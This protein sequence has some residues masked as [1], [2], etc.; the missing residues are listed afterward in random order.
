MEGLQDDRCFSVNSVA[1]NV[2]DSRRNSRPQLP[3]EFS[4]TYE[5][6]DTS[7]GQNSRNLQTA[8]LDP[9]PSYRLENLMSLTG[10]G[11]DITEQQWGSTAGYPSI[12]SSQATETGVNYSE[13]TQRTAHTTDTEITVPHGSTTHEST[14]WLIHP[15]Q[16]NYAK[17]KRPLNVL[18]DM[19]QPKRH[20]SSRPAAANTPGSGLAHI[21]IDMPTSTVFQCYMLNDPSLH[22]TPDHIAAFGVL[23]RIAYESIHRWFYAYSLSQRAG[24]VMSM[25]YQ[26]VSDASKFATKLF[27]Y[28]IEANPGRIPDPDHISALHTLT[29]IEYSTI[30]KWFHR[31]VEEFRVPRNFAQEQHNTPRGEPAHFSH[32]DTVAPSIALNSSHFQEA[33]KNHSSERPKCTEERT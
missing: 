5:H 30:H 3:T 25:T 4:S 13:I 22:L 6:N 12:S 11:G 23:T 24:E 18:A 31:N 2:P 27:R 33:A 8:T 17:H 20:K 26:E 29:R 16:V 19:A 14:N 21:D 32:N 7:D 1:P 9:S 10:A 15:Q 28:W